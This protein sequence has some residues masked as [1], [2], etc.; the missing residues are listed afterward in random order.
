MYALPVEARVSRWGQPADNIAGTLDW[1][2]HR[3]VALRP[4]FREAL[5]KLD[6]SGRV[7][8]L[9]VDGGTTLMHR[10]EIGELRRGALKG[11]LQPAER[12]VV[13]SQRRKRFGPEEARVLLRVLPR[14]GEG[15]DENKLER[16]LAIGLSEQRQGFG[17]APVAQGDIRPGRC[18]KTGNDPLPSCW[19]AQLFKLPSVAKCPLALVQPG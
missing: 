6:G 9:L 4:Q 3:R 19:R 7:A 16:D 2:L 8:T 13:T 14:G 5:V 10:G 17:C 15:L 1:R 12:F 11:H 18:H